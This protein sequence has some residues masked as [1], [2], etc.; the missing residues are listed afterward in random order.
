VKSIDEL[1]SA[2]DGAGKRPAILVQRGEA[3][4]YVPVEIG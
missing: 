1:K 4:I 2:I 3:T